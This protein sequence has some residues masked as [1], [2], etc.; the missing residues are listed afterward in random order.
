MAMFAWRASPS[1]SLS[2]IARLP[3][4]PGSGPVA[5]QLSWLFPGGPPRV[6]TRPDPFGYNP[7]FVPRETLPMNK[8]ANRLSQKC[9]DA[10]RVT[11]KSP[12]DV[13]RVEGLMPMLRTAA[14]SHNIDPVMLAAIAL[15]ESGGR[16]IAEIG[17]GSGMGVFQLTNQPHVTKVQA[18]DV[19]FAADYAAKMLANN[20]RYLARHHPNFTA[21]QQRQATFASYNK[22]FGHGR[23]LITDDPATIDAGTPGGNYGRNVL[24]LMSCF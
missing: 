3:G 6:D 10:L 24:D 17:K 12:N 18:Y 5:N 1:P 23:S 16:N 20:R 4:P 2:D 11:N 14:A 22:F 13:D 19:R 9:L 15:R 7:P 8:Q 21:D